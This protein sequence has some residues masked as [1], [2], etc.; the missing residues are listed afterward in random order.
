M[1]K[2]ELTTIA[3][4]QSP[5]KE[6]FGIPRQA[7]VIESSIAKVPFQLTQ[8]NREAFKLFEGFSHIWLVYIFHENIG[9]WKP[10]VRPP[11]LGGN[12]SVGVFASRSPFRP[13]PI[14]FSV[15]KLERI[16]EEKKQLI[17]EVSGVDL[18]DGTPIVDIKPYIAYSDAIP[19]A[20]Q[21]WVE[22]NEW[23][24]LEVKFSPE[25]ETTLQ[26]VYSKYPHLRDLIEETL[27]QDPRPA[28]KRDDYEKLY[29]FRLYD[30][31][32]KW[33][34]N[35]NHCRVLKIQKVK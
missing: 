21:G 33:Q 19:D 16:Y 12:K 9:R 18:V 27:T 24:F 28:Y 30:Y 2:F 4:I 10:R 22:E 6:K 26:Q 35:E 14:G 31:D 1:D 20:S 25:S 7:N 29:A 3:H 32:V 34:V 15:V 17:L 11:R 8:E 5:F 23:T 13:N